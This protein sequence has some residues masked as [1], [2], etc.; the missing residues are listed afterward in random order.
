M[1]Y[2]SLLSR[3]AHGGKGKEK[4]TDRDKDVEDV[5]D[6]L[7]ELRQAM[8]I[9]VKMKLMEAGPM[10]FLLEKLRVAEGLVFLL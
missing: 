3:H 1:F 7:A 9:T 6:A 2:A 5:S 10:E 4:A 8:E